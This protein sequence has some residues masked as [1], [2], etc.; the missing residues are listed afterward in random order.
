MTNLGIL[1]STFFILERTYVL[2]ISDNLKVSYIAV[3]LAA[4]V[5]NE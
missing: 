1:C 5:A 4:A 2:M 3:L